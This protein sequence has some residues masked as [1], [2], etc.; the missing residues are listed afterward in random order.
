MAVPTLQ[1]Y[2]DRVSGVAAQRRG[3]PPDVS[4]IT[5]V[6]KGAGTIARTIRSVQAQ[7]GVTVEHIVVDGASP[8]GTAD[9]ARTLLR[10]Q[11]L[12]LSEPDQGISDAFNKGIALARG[13]FVQMLNA[14]DWM[15]EGQLAASVARLRQ[16]GAD[17]VYGDLLF[18]RDGAPAFRYHGE[19]DYAACID[20]RM[21]ALNHPT[22]VARL[23]AFERIGLFDLRYRCAM[24]YDWFL[25]LHRA[26]G[27]GVYEPSILGHMTH[28]G[29]SNLRFRRT[30]A[31]VRDIAV[32]YGRSPVMASAEA[33]VRVAKTTVGQ[34]VRQ[35]N[36]A[37]YEQVRRTINSAYRP[38]DS[39]R[40]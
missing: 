24:D 3:P 9:V 16:T 11:D 15:S 36:P 19:A 40:P 10:E 23:S 17:F 7:T 5:A 26:G 2:R 34:Y 35:V 18:H 28:E 38:L 6:F 33:A 32:A 31:E 30:I 14:D 1:Q 25:R 21:P 39:G 20:S 37:F 13:T 29:V 8:D 22:V 12:V 4:V 27:R